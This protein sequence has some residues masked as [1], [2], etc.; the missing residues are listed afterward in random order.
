MGKDK[1]KEGDKKASKNDESKALAKKDLEALDAKPQSPLMIVDETQKKSKE[2]CKEGEESPVMD[3][4]PDQESIKVQ[5]DEKNRLVEEYYDR[6]LRTQAE[7]ENLKKRTEKELNDFKTYANAQL[8]KDLLFVLDDFQ[9]ALATEKNGSTDNFMKG[10][11]LIYQNF[12]SM[13]EKEGLKIINETEEKFDPWKHEAV[14]METTDDYPENTVIDVI[15]PGYKFRDK[16]LRPAKV[17]VAVEPKSEEEVSKEK[18]DKDEGIDK[19]NEMK[20]D[21]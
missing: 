6:L 11:E 8:I 7:L 1:Q 21:E 10:V 16:V 18:I 17:R 13:L 2:G 3:K 4:E 14:E 15:Q 5:L 19:G 20:D 9:T 12:Y